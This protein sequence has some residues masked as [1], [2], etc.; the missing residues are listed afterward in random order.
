MKRAIYSIPAGTTVESLTPEQQAAI[1]GVFAQFVNPQPGTSVFE[2]RQIVD[3]VVGD[4]FDPT[5]LEALGMEDW[6]L[7]GLW[8]WDGTG[9]LVT[10]QP[11]D[12]DDYMQYVPDVVQYDDDG[13]VAGASPAERRIQHSWAGWPKS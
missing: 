9:A 6:T 10:I 3:G 11:L 5:V 12:L 13:N 2:D 7:M 8:Q 1:A 4:N